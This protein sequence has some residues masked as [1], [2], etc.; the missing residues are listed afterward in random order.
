MIPVHLNVDTSSE[1][2]A[3]RACY[4]LS[5]TGNQMFPPAP[6]TFLRQ[7]SVKTYFAFSNH[8]QIHCV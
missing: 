8:D 3:M 4:M 6:L 7:Y 5:L 2:A 1:C